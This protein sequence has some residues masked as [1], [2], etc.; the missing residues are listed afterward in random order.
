LP[1][2][3]GHL[4]NPELVRIVSSEVDIATVSLTKARLMRKRR[5]KKEKETVMIDIRLRLEER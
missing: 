4:A 2:R 3:V 1:L 5:N